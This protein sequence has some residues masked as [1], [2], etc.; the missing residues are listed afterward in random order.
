MKILRGSMAAPKGNTYAKGKATGRPKIWTDEA[1]EEEANALLEFIA[2]DGGLYI[3]TFCRQRRFNPDRLQEWAR[4]NE[5]FASALS[6]AKV[7][8]EEKFLQKG[9]NRE[10]DSGFTRYAMARTCGDKWKAS[11]DAA[12]DPEALKQAVQTVVQNYGTAQ[13]QGEGWQKPKSE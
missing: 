3:N 8:Q 11:Y 7:W 5:V 9:L 12:V 2:K 10:W 1:I 13:Q 6:E 4:S